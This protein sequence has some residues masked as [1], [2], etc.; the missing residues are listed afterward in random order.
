MSKN[1]S[2]KYYQE[3]KEWLQKK[4]HETYQNLSKVEKEKKATIWPWTLK[5]STRRCKRETVWV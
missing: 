4:A 5:I 1:L 2:A 3:N